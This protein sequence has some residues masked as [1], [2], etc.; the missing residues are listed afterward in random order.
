MRLPYSSDSLLQSLFNLIHD[1]YAYADVWT[2]KYANNCRFILVVLI[3][4]SKS[5]VPLPIA[6]VDP[7]L[8]PSLKT[9]MWY[10]WHASSDG[11]RPVRKNLSL[12]FL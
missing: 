5:M 6:E 3:F 9:Y 12:E 8:F 7:K 10:M 2:K 4:E 11:I 1:L